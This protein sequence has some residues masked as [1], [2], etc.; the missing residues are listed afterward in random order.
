MKRVVEYAPEKQPTENRQR[1]RDGPLFS[2]AKFQIKESR[3]GARRDKTEQPDSHEKAN[4]PTADGNGSFA[5][6]DRINFWF[7]I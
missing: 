7:R 5:L 6:K 1:E 4:D 3:D 2:R